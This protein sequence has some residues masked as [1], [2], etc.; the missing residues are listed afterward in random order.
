M[1]ENTKKSDPKKTLW[2]GSTYFAEGLPYMLVRYLTSVYLTD[3]GLKESY[4]GFVNFLG[5]P[6]NFKFLWA[7]AVDLVS[8]KRRWLLWIE[9]ALTFGFAII[10]L[11]ATI[12]PE[13]VATG[14]ALSMTPMQGLAVKAMITL[15]IM[16]AFLSATHDIAIDGFY[17]EAISD[18][19]EQA[20][21][22]GLRVLTYR[23]AVI[24]TKSL[25]V[26]LA[27]WV[28]WSAGWFGAALTLAI[29]VAFHAWY[30]PSV[31]QKKERQTDFKA[32]ARNYGRAFSTYLAQD[33]VWLILL[34][35]V[36][37]KLGDELLFSM[38]TPF[39]MR[40]LG[41]TKP[42][43]SWI[44]GIFGTSASII[45]SL[46]SA[47][48]IKK[49]GL[50]KAIWPLTLAM[51]LNI[52]AYIWLAWALPDPTTAGGLATIAIVNSYE[53]FA[54]GLGNAVLVVFI[55]RTCSSE[56]KAAHYA[57]ASAI[58]SVGGTLFGGFGGLFVEAFGY[59]NLYLTAFAATIPGMT[60]LLFLRI[61][62]E[63]CSTV[64][65][66]DS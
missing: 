4:L 37:Y 66:L 18:P 5:I 39:L 49:Y 35:V 63:P 29:L 44:S 19:H 10:A 62:A 65:K 52:W 41:V 43:L 56:F 46:I 57:I 61:P 6:W 64:Q 23:L 48:A 45:G 12:G 16:L 13:T 3:I 22:T 26:A 17:M 2:V 47:W 42:Q 51:N 32:F 60:C 53:Q 40:E 1:A 14:T 33:R 50:V 27:G 54:A 28:S 9:L 24:F 11:L 15:M 58:A 31:E 34:F 7:P 30:L 36:T 20:G 59:V 21:F 38:N 8:T 25:L 55:M